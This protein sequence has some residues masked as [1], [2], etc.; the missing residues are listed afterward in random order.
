MCA[1]RIWAARLR[2]STC[3]EGSR[4][5]S[6]SSACH[7]GNSP[8]LSHGK[9]VYPSQDTPDQVGANHTSHHGLKGLWCS[10]DQW[11]AAP[12]TPAGLPA[13]YACATSLGRLLC[14][15]QPISC[16]PR[17]RPNTRMQ[18]SCSAHAGLVG[19]RSAAADLRRHGGSGCGLGGGGAP[20]CLAELSSCCLS[21]TASCSMSRAR[22][23]ELRPPRARVWA[24]FFRAQMRSAGGTAALRLVM[25]SGPPPSAP[26]WPRSASSS[27]AAWRACEAP[28]AAQGWSGTGAQ[29][30]SGQGMMSAAS[31]QLLWS[32]AQA[33]ASLP[34]H[35]H[36]LKDLKVTVSEMLF[37]AACRGPQPGAV[38]AVHA[39]PSG[40]I[41]Q[42]LTSRS[43]RALTRRWRAA[44]EALV[45]ASRSISCATGLDCPS[46]VATR[47][48]AGARASCKAGEK[49][50]GS[51]T[52]LGQT[53]AASTAVMAAWGVCRRRWT[54]MPCT[55]L[56]RAHRWRVF[57][58]QIWPPKQARS[59]LPSSA[60]TVLTG[61][62]SS[63]GKPRCTCTCTCRMTSCLAVG[64]TYNM[65]DAMQHADD[66][67]RMRWCS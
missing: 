6:S 52:G 64:E 58:L 9:P 59:H 19:D 33:A 41:Q 45:S 56:Q 46:T 63:A 15:G 25:A 47:S 60:S 28:Y 44:G 37:P 62:R 1:C 49:E 13:I 12:P 50:S 40:A 65:G 66:S 43:W 54:T 57:Q 55:L 39:K 27:A 2:A 34:A 11:A 61:C 23:Q 36:Q 10:R 7:S 51:S 35:H 26:D 32:G 5:S 42:G 29:G 4:C 8:A 14:P 17:T 31:W 24:T 38:E 18:L 22:G 21:S 16:S 3:Q 53:C 67:P 30:I 48:A 20:G